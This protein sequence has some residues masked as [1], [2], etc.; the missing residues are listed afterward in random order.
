MHPIHF[1][2]AGLPIHVDAIKA[3]GEWAADK[4]AHDNNVARIWLGVDA[5]SPKDVLMVVTYQN[6]FEETLVADADN[7]WLWNEVVP[8]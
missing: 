8:A 3:A 4:Q 2:T 7:D 6:G 5:D 1:A